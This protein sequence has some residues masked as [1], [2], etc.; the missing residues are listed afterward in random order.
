VVFG[1][2]DAER[3]EIIVAVVW[4]PTVWT[5]TCVSTP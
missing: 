5:Q 3:G 2:D 1:F 4:P